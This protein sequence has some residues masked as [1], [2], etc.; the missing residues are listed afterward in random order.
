MTDP[1]STA[2]SVPDLALGHV[3]A[4]YEAAAR[5]RPRGGLG[6]PPVRPRQQPVDDRRARG[7]GHRRAARLARCAGPLH[8]ADPGPRG[9]RRRHRRGRLHDRRGRRHGRQQP[10]PG[11]PASDLRDA[12]GL[13]G[14]APP[15]LDRSG[16][17]RRGLRRPRSAPD[18]DH[19]GQQ[20]GHDDRAQRVPGRGLGAAP[21]QARRGRP[22][23]LP[24]A[25][26]GH[27]GHH[28]PGQEPGRHR[29]PRRVPLGLP[30]P[31]G[32][33][34]P[35]LGADLRRPRA[36]LAHRPGPGRPAGQRGGHA[37]RLP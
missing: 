33:R 10:G 11:R 30:E 27:R 34:R 9:L 25:R 3:T 15:R 29:P 17:H 12:G 35:L 18:A 1:T 36:G 13:P 20:V 8:R 28:R 26:R 24:D 31:A 7:R 5:A 37:R 22:S 2:L 19:R 16:Q 32:H 4:E 6:D 23:R 14:P 21:R